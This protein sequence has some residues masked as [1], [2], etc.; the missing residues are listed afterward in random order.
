M[1]DPKSTGFTASATGR[2]ASTAS[3]F[4]IPLPYTASPGES[5]LKAVSTGGRAGAIHATRFQRGETGLLLGKYSGKSTKARTGPTNSLDTNNKA[6]VRGSEPGSARMPKIAYCSPKPRIALPNAPPRKSQPTRLSGGR[7][8]TSPPTTAPETQIRG[9]PRPANDSWAGSASTNAPARKSQ[10]QRAQP[11]PFKRALERWSARVAGADLLGSRRLCSRSLS[12]IPSGS[13]IQVTQGDSGGEVPTHAVHTHSGRRRGR[14]DIEPLR[15][16]RVRVESGHGPGEELSEIHD[17][18]VDVAAHQ[19]GVESFEVRR[20]H[21]VLG[22]DALLEARG[23]AFD[24]GLDPPCHV[25]GRAVG[26]VAVGPNGMLARRRAGRVEEALLRQQHER[27]LGMLAAPHGGFTGGDLLQRA[28]EVDGPGPQA[29]DGPPGDRAVEREI[30]L[31]DAGTVTVILEG[32]PVALGDV[33]P[34]DV[35]QLAGRDVEEDRARARHL[36]DRVHP[37]AGEDLAA[38][39]DQVRGEGVGYLLRPALRERPAEGVP[40]SA[41]DEPEESARGLLQ[42]QERV[43][44]VTRKEAAGLLPLERALGQ[45]ARR[46]EGAQRRGTQ[47]EGM[48]DEAGRADEVGCNL[49]SVFCHA[50]HEPLVRPGV[51][52]KSGG[53]LL[54]GALKDGGGTVVEGVGERGRGVDP[55]EAVLL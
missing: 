28:S 10:R 8:A 18:A 48:P 35:E 40:Q 1:Y 38:E 52:A 13:L 47:G 46:A 45:G 24:L 23:E 43:S 27:S 26:D 41:E 29:L 20:S 22:Q 50:L 16:R 9:N 5:V 39:G 33:R 15:R 49:G 36:L 7:E 14:A 42:R 54:H 11:S 51:G 19:V 21:R 37:D 2:K 30:Y 3:R 6:P 34:R 44:R 12:G 4:G 31:E 25:E 32:A 55:L 53:R 17:A